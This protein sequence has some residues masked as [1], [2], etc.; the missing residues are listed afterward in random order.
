MTAEGFG[1]NDYAYSEML[2]KVITRSRE[3]YVL[4]DSSKVDK[5]AANLYA[6]LEEITA[7]ITDERRSRAI[8]CRPLRKRASTVIVAR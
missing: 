8:C 4:A 7:W 2:H 5:R 6:R 1:C 3:A